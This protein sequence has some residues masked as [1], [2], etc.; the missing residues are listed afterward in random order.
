[1]IFCVELTDKR[2]SYVIKKLASLG[3]MTKEFKFGNA[4]LDTENV[5]YIFAPARKLLISEI[6]ELVPNSK[7]FGGEQKSEILINLEQKNIKYKNLLSSEVIT[8]QNALLTA[9]GVLSLLIQN[10]DKSIFYLKTLILGGGRVGKAIAVLN[11]RLG[12]DT[13]IANRSENNYASAYLFCKDAIRIDE[14][15]EKIADYDVIINTVPAQI[16]T[17]NILRKVADNA[18]IMEV[19]SVSCLNIQNLYNYKFKF[20]S[21]PALPGKFSPCTAGEI[22]VQEILKD[23]T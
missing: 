1:M 20:L 19:A 10:T 15:Q 7:V 2:N 11:T 14:L 9:E 6:C 18:L 13:T 16:L 4:V 8:V 22:I 3:Y 12:I 5:I 23:F 21:A 17:D